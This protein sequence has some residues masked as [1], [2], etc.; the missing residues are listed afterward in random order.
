[1][2][3]LCKHSSTEGTHSIHMNINPISDFP[4]LSSKCQVTGNED[5]LSAYS[6]CINPFNFSGARKRVKWHSLVDWAQRPF[7]FPVF[8]RWLGKVLSAIAGTDTV[9]L[10]IKLL[11]LP[12]PVGTKG[13][14][15]ET[16][17]CS[18]VINGTLVLDITHGFP[19]P[20]PDRVLISWCCCRTQWCEGKPEKFLF[21]YSSLVEMTLVLIN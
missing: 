10:E 11:Q 18:S 16:K 8:P 6:W 14:D 5:K 20:H 1:M 4:L 3:T 9:S 12:A 17:R 19:P 15:S 2:C 13:S 21:L 7:G